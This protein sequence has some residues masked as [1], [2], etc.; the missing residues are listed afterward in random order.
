MITFIDFS[1][2]LCDVMILILNYEIWI[3]HFFVRY[4]EKYL[5]EISFFLT[6]YTEFYT[7]KEVHWWKKIRLLTFLVKNLSVKN[8]YLYSFHTHIIESIQTPTKV[9]GQKQ[10]HQQK[11]SKYI[12]IYFSSNHN[13]HKCLCGHCFWASD[14]LIERF[15]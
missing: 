2:C 3:I 12:F 8:R 9:Q 5:W 7:Q 10:N 15:Y 11:T 14:P 1:F 6:M 4:I 13:V